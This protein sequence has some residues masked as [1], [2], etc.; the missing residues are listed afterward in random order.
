MKINPF[1]KP[2]ILVC[3][4]CGAEM[5][6]WISP[7]LAAMLLELTHDA[8]FDVK[9]EFIRGARPTEFARNLTMQKARDG[10]YDWLVSLD[11]DIFMPRG[12][13]LDVIAKAGERSVIGLTYGLETQSGVYTL[14]PHGGGA[15]EGKFAEVPFVGGGCLMVNRKVWEKI[16]RGPWFRMQLGNDETLNPNNGGLIEDQFFCRLAQQN[17]FRVWTHLEI[18]AGHYH[19]SDITEIALKALHAGKAGAR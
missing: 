18:F 6:Y 7:R 2:K 10:G 4:L 8:R 12:T 5:Q 3:V 19:T 14:V 11:A 9:F 17:G 1:S 16:P 15:I 13:P